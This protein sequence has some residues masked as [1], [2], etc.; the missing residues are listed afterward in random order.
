MNQG[1][2]W[3]NAMTEVWVNAAKAGDQR[4]FEKIYQQY[5]PILYS[6]LLR[7]VKDTEVAENLLQDSFVKIWSNTSQYDPS[8]GRFFIWMYRICKNCCIDYT[9]SRRYKHNRMTLLTED[10]SS[11][12]GKIPGHSFSP[13]HIGLRKIVSKLCGEEKE[14]IELL[15]FKGYTQA[16]VAQLKSIPLGT[17]KTRSFKAIRNLRKFFIPDETGFNQAALV[18]AV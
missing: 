17:V 9:R 11:L 18:L 2:Q 8:R 7:W 6:A 15:Y 10:L 5:A 13:D 4:A 16:E 12:A 3:E 14:I 1:I